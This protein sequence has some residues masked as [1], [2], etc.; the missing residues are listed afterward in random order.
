MWA[1]VR[2]MRAAPALATAILCGCAAGPDFVR[3]A[4]PPETSYL[5]GGDPVATQAALGAAQRF[6]AGAEVAPDWWRLFGSPE[7]E[8]AMQAALVGNL[9]L[10][11]AQAAL[12]ESQAN[13][14]AGQGVFYPQ[15]DL[16]FDARRQ[17]S[18]PITAGIAPLGGVFN[19]FTLAGTVSYLLDLSGA[20]RR[21]VEAL[22]AQVDVQHGEMLATWLSLSGN[23]VNTL[24]ARAAYA[25]QMRA[26]GELIARE[27]EQLEI[28]RAQY[29]GGSTA[30]AGV[31]SIE[32][33]LASS[34]AQLP[35]L[36]QRY[37]QASH[38]LAVLAGRAP[39]AWQA[40][41]VTLDRLTLPRDLP[42]VVP[43]QLVRQRPDILA[44]EAR[45]HAA[46]ANLGIASAALFP[47]VTLGAQYGTE[48]AH[49]DRFTGPHN[50]F[51]NTG[52]L[53]D[54]PVFHGGTLVYQRDAAAQA[55]QRALADYRQ[56]VLSAFQ[57]VADTLTALDNDARALQA[58]A[59]AVAA[60][61]QSVD[62]LQANYRAG[63][64]SYLQVL[65]ADVQ[66]HRAQVDF[67]QAR[68]LQLQ[69]TAALY[70]AMGGGWR[71]MPAPAL[72]GVRR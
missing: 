51:W 49:I 7:L 54:I 52:A 5:P 6:R 27:A 19:I 36:Q 40:P 8:H 11:S 3:P 58:Q 46:S 13:L 71:S 35:A 48:G 72:E 25:E 55:L 21:T 65:V 32:S 61:R 15:L 50:R 34:R 60:A 30:Y 44:A 39:S 38:L 63:L 59:E 20:N 41:P 69:D 28:A 31:V 43:S 12:R 66:L 2:S 26:T 10:Q 4:P 33:Q 47:S 29:A 70:L 17:R 57:Q 23:V 53:A 67:T 22:A 9:S 16:A 14:R 45:L 37:E 24:I 1:T 62:L 56:T 64:V 68:A 42:L 18:A